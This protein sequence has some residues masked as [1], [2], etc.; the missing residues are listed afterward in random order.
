[1]ARKVILDFTEVE[2]E[3][4]YELLSEERE[5]L[6]GEALDKEVLLLEGTIGTWRGRFEIIPLFLT[7]EEYEMRRL[8]ELPVYEVFYDN[9]GEIK[10]I[11]VKISHH[12]GTNYYT[13][14]PIKKAR[15]KQ[16][17]NA[18]KEIEDTKY[19]NETLQHDRGVSFSRA[20]KEDLIY[21]IENYV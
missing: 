12:D 13:L 10:K 20:R 19:I 18:L 8:P 7:F 16:L 21:Y 3:V 5:A 6:I 11:E 1:M 17:K 14:T 9:K 15:V 2:N 4:Q